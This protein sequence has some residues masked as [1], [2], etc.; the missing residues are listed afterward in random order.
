MLLF[1]PSVGRQ[2]G[3]GLSCECFVT[4]E[5]S[6]IIEF[7]AYQLLILYGLTLYPPYPFLGCYTLH[8]IIIVV[9]GR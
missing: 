2:L 1:L 7:L 8:F 6:E 9:T 4:I 5:N 3:F